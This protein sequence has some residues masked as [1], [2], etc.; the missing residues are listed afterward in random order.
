VSAAN[1]A[2]QLTMYTRRV[3]WLSATMGMIVGGAVP[4]LWG[5]SQIGV[6]SLFLGTLGGIAGVW[7]GF[8]LTN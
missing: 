7:A 8:Y 4:A 2:D 5:G 1:G 3:I 6:A